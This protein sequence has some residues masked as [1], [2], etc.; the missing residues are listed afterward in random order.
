MNP[1]TGDASRVF[2]AAAS[3]RG[4]PADRLN[5]RVG[6]DV[7]SCRVA[8]PL[9]RCA[10]TEGRSLCFA[11]SSET[12]SPPRPK[13]GFLLTR[14]M[15]LDRGT[16]P[17][18]AEARTGPSARP[19]PAL[20]REGNCARTADTVGRARP[21]TESQASS[22]PTGS[23]RLSRLGRERTGRACL[24]LLSRVEPRQCSVTPITSPT[25]SATAPVRNSS[26]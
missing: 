25:T 2:P 3:R 18:P 12:A 15:W 17:G 1:Q 20:R 14:A 6:S 13:D 7:Q 22:G 9:R 4:G 11:L 5:R 26:R 19:G 16:P 23:G 10:R 21:R 8:L 24:L